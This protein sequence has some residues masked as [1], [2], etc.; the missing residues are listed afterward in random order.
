MSFGS[1]SLVIIRGCICKKEKTRHIILNPP[2]PPV[3][4]LFSLLACRNCFTIRT[5]SLRP[6][7]SSNHS[8]ISFAASIPFVLSNETSMWIPECGSTN[9]MIGTRALA[10]TSTSV[11][12][13]FFL[14]GLLT[15]T[16]YSYFPYHQVC[17]L[18][19]NQYRNQANTNR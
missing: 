18:P 12:K 19:R 5:N 15:N 1:I 14:N 4:T 9:L 7:V 17:S 2:R 10:T 8:L 3:C 11:A 16:S 13:F 6:G